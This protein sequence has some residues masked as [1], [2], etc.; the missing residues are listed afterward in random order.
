MNT[1]PAKRA[2]EKQEK[3]IGVFSAEQ[4]DLIKRTIAKGA[5]DDELRLFLYQAGRTGL[6]PLAR[7]IYSIERREKRGDEWVRVR[8][9]QTSIDGFRLIAERSGQY[10]GQL[11]PEWCG[12]DGIWRDVWLCEEP[13]AAARVGVM[14][15]DFEKP[16]WGIARFRAYAAFNKDGS[17]RALWRTM[18]DVMIA[19]C[20]EALALR[21]AFPQELSGLYTSDEM[22][23]ASSEATKPTQSLA[24]ELDDEIPEYADA[25]RSA[26]GSASAAAHS[27]LASGAAAT[28]SLEDMAREAARHGPDMLREF[29]NKRSKDDQKRLREIEKELIKLYPPPMA[30]HREDD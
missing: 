21:K 10:A 12:N 20:A 28:L 26:S 16:C 9:I 1:L 25:A 5:T 7:Q 18:A 19:K 24:D 29:F 14:R 15:K 30:Q 13:P 17:P 11:G 3:Q 6:D 23:Q 4:V 2:T 27:P 22:L 8:S